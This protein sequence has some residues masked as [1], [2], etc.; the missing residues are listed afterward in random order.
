MFPTLF[1]SQSAKTKILLDKFQSVVDLNLVNHLY[2]KN[3][4][5]NISKVIF[6]VCISV[7]VKQLTN[8]KVQ[9]FLKIILFFQIFLY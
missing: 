5:W 7:V 2:G 8:I 4:S 6:T 3:G 1:L 9:K